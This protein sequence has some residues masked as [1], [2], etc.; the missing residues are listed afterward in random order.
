MSDPSDGVC[1]DGLAWPTAAS[2]PGGVRRIALTLALIW[3]AACGSTLP[4]TPT[5]DPRIDLL[6][7]QLRE[8]GETVQR[9]D[10]QV[11]R[12]GEPVATASATPFPSPTPTPTPTPAATATPLPSPTPASTPTPGPSREEIL[13]LVDEIVREAIPSIPTAAAGPT[14]RQFEELSESVAEIGSQPTPT[15]GVTLGEIEELIQVEITTAIAAIPTPRTV[16]TPTPVILSALAKIVPQISGPSEARF[17]GDLLLTLEPGQPLAGRDISF[18]LTGLPPWQDIRVGF[19]D[20]LGVPALWITED[21]ATFAPVNGRPITTRTVYADGDGAASWLRIGTQD[22]EG[23]WSVDITVAGDTTS[24]SYTVAELQ[25]PVQEITNVGVELRRY[26]GQLSD[27]FY[28]AR[29]PG[30]L[31]VEFQSQLGW[32]ADRIAEILGIHS[33]KIPD[34]Y[35][36]GNESLLVQIGAAV[37]QDVGFE[38]GFFL[39]S[40]GRPGIY[41]RTDAYIAELQA[42]LAHEYLHLLVSERTNNASLPAWLNEGLA[43][44]LEFELGVQGTRPR[45]ARRNFYDSAERAKAAALSGELLPLMSL[46]SQGDWVAQQDDRVIQL[47]YAEAHMA[48]RYLTEQHGSGAALNILQQIAAGADLGLA[49]RTQTGVSYED[50]QEGFLAWLRTWQDEARTSVGGYI[51]AANEVMATVSSIVERRSDELENADRLSSSDR[52]PIKRSLLADA[53]ASQNKIA[54]TTPPDPLVQL[55]QET[56]AYLDVLVAWLSL[57]LSFIE[58]GQDSKR[59]AANEM[60]SEVDGRGSRLS[61]SIRRV[62]FEYQLP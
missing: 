14:S 18:T 51:D 11:G 56:L 20:P 21:E 35:L 53:Q 7:S 58:T 2:L 24:I 29:V 22:S 8:I 23:V 59:V 10:E 40:G 1:F 50:L 6:E 33:R 39:G 62:E 42:T 4:A 60:I 46:Q 31:A 52:L 48:V 28:S 30:T 41:M 32:F 25:V 34:I 47:Q 49:I 43:E 54:A 3:V 44:Y 27:T 37:G 9:V 12:L 16:P 13:S 57:E 61:R 26:Q 15:P 36:L 38:F 19:V 55:H 17:Q 45:V 5:P